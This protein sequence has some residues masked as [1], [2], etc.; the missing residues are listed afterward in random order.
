MIQLL[1][2]LLGK[3]LLFG[4]LSSHPSNNKAILNLLYLF[5]NIL[6]AL[7]APAFFASASNCFEW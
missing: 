7:F 5:G 3:P 2:V 1:Y 6:F 4:L